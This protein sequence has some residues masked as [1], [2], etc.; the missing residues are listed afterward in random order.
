MAF[1]KYENTGYVPMGNSFSLGYYVNLQAS[2]KPL[3]STYFSTLLEVPVFQPNIVSKSLFMENYRAYQF[4]AFGLMPVYKFSR[5]FHAKAEAYTFV[6]VQEILRDSNNKAYLG[7]FFES[8]KTLFNASVN[9]VT[10]AGPVSFHVGY[11]TEE[12]DPWVIQLSFGYLLFN[13]RSVDE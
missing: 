1:R 12:E 5:R 4:A 8:V 7:N 13:K 10:V 3:L 11:I 9:M 6:P 2:F